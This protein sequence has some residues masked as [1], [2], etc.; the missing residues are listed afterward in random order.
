[1]YKRQVIVDFDGTDTTISQT[2]IDTVSGSS[3]SVVGVIT[4]RFENDL[5]K[6]QCE[7]DRVNVLEVRSNIVGLGTTTAGT[8]THRFATTGQP[9]GLERSVRLESGYVTGTASTITY[10]T[11]SKQIDSS[12]KSIVRVSCGETSA[13]HQVISIRDLD[14]SLIHI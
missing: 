9:S 7:N 1:M 13:I 10:S 11:I 6:L 2:Y 8:G 3:S 4:A 5:I 14:L 12:V